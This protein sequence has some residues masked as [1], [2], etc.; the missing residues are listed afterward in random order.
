MTRGSLFRR[1]KILYDTGMTN[2]REITKRANTGIY[3]YNCCKNHA[4]EIKK[5]YFFIL[6]KMIVLELI[7]K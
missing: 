6:Q 2:A 5:T 4:S 3:A 1:V 7:T